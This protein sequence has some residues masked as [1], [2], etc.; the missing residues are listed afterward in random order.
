MENIIFIETMAQPKGLLNLLPII[1]FIVLIIALI[2]LIIGFIFSR[3]LLYYLACQ[4]QV[5]L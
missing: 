3:T 5:N 4:E 2:G 1:I